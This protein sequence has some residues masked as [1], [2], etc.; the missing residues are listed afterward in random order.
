MYIETKELLSML[1]IQFIMF[2]SVCGKMTAYMR[3]WY[4]KEYHVDE[5]HRLMEQDAER[6]AKRSA[7]IQCLLLSSFPYIAIIFIRGLFIK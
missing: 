5:N 6:H 2:T 7:W 3:E 4:R 1:F